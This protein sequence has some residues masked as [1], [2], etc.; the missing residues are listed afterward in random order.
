[1][2][3]VATRQPIGRFRPSAQRPP[4]GRWKVI[5]IA[6][7]AALVVGLSIRFVI[8]DQDDTAQTEPG[9]VP[10]DAQIVGDGEQGGVVPANAAENVT[11]GGIVLTPPFR[12]PSGTRSAEL[13]PSLG[14]VS[15]IQD[16]DL[17]KVP[18]IVA[19]A[20]ITGGRIAAKTAQ[21]ADLTGDG[22]DEALVAVTSEGSFGNLGYFVV[23]LNDG[24]PEII[25]EI[26]AEPSSRHGV[27]VQT[28]GGGIVETSGI[29][30]PDD[31]NCCPTSL[32]MTYYFWDGQEFQIYASEI[33]WNI[34][35]LE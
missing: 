20:Q 35:K 24:W 31:P 6:G 33:L 1:M 34:G 16:I 3:Y 19:Y 21:F 22:R 26:V 15:R 8:G 17:T 10:Q 25:R 13:S 12:K 23:T 29:Y 18:E 30:G 32:R 14:G 27:N 28:E 7:V 5:I 4:T 11:T 9:L 2:A